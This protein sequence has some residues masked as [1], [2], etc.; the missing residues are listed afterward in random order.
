[1]DD[2]GAYITWEFIDYC[3]TNKIKLVLLPA[4]AMHF[5]HIRT[6]GSNRTVAKDKNLVTGQVARAMSDGS[7]SDR[8]GYK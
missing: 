4:Y 7:Y 2:C 3:N 6:K 1:M 8:V 5:L